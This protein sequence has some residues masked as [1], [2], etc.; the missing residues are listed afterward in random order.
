M[1]KGLKE[2]MGW[3][4]TDTITLKRIESL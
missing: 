4:K 3:I 1:E 2:Y